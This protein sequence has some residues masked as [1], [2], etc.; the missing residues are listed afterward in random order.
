MTGKAVMNIRWY[1]LAQKKK[2]KMISLED[3]DRT[4]DTKLLSIRKHG[5]ADLNRKL[6]ILTGT[7]NRSEINLHSRTECDE[8]HKERGVGGKASRVKSKHICTLVSHLRAISC[9]TPIDK[10]EGSRFN[11]PASLW[12][13]LL[14]DTWFLD[15]PTSARNFNQLMDIQE[16]L[17]I[18]NRISFI[19]FTA[20][21][22]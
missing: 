20:A 1:L 3:S 21:I 10:G 2:H 19:K 7:H 8:Q 11:F 17:V 15:T 4:K 14:L 16:A 5:F 6:Q 9:S 13:S 18:I 12:H 22:F